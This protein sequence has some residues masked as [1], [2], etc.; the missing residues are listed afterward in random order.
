MK[1]NISVSAFMAFLKGNLTRV[2]RTGGGEGGENFAEQKFLLMQGRVQP[3][4]EGNAE[5][6]SSGFTASQP[7][8]AEGA[9]GHPR[10]QARQHRVPRADRTG[11]LNVPRDPTGSG[12]PH[13][14]LGR[15]NTCN[16]IKLVKVAVGPQ[17]SFMNR[18][19]TRQ[20]FQF[21]YQN[22]PSLVR[23]KSLL[24]SVI[25]QNELWL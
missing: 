25:S 5:E 24:H 13:N 22:F 11:G 1:Y 19:G 21:M 18:A 16:P 2:E 12:R 23:L 8:W 3:L 9:S 14:T 7:G 20:V 15:D 17:V 6:I 10:S 4:G